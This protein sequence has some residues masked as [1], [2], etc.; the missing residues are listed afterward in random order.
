MSPLPQELT[1]D[2]RVNRVSPAIKAQALSYARHA[3]P[4][5]RPAYCVRL[6]FDRD[7]STD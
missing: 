3:R 4:Q 7:V 2:V 1:H 5:V 6:N